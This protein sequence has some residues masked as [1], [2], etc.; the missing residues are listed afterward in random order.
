M[1]DRPVD[2]RSPALKSTDTDPALYAAVE[3]AQPR[4]FVRLP[5]PA[6]EFKR[7]GLAM[8]GATS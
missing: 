8:A 1:P 3:G 7:R 6:P 4:P 5:R 2:R